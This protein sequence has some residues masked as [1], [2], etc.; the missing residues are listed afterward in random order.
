MYWFSRAFGVLVVLALLV[1]TWAQDAKDKPAKDKKDVVAKDK[2]KTNPKIK[3][4]DDAPEEKV[5][6]GAILLGKL[7]QMDAN[8][9]KDFTLTIYGKE[10]DPAQQN[11]LVRLT[12]QLAVQQAQLRQY[13]LSKDFNSA[14]QRQLDIINT[15]NAIAQTKLKLF[16][17]KEIDVE[18]R[19]AD[20]VKVRSEFLPTEYDDKGNLKKWTEKEKKAL[21]GNSKLPGY[22]AEYDALRPG[23]GV[24]IYLAKALS[25]AAPKGLKTEEPMETMRP[26]VVMIHIVQEAQ[27]PQR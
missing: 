12:N 15:N 23:Q 1:P 4:K 22:P 19:A 14:R 3:P 6:Y 20:N 9:Q 5:S 26:E 18:L 2:K 11:E 24:K 27:A 16:R 8:S 7:K 25:K 21:K 10:P 17:T 13:L